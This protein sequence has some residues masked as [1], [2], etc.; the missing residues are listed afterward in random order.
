MMAIVLELRSRKVALEEP[1]RVSCFVLGPRETS[2][3]THLRKFTLGMGIDVE[4]LEDV[5]P[6]Q[7][8]M[9]GEGVP[10]P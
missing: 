3:G 10:L 2:V 1:G 4:L 9:I 8:V 6:H 7:I 5:A